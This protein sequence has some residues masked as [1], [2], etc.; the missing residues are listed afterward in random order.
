[1]VSPPFT[2]VF[3]GELLRAEKLT[4]CSARLKPLNHT[5]SLS[6]EETARRNMIQSCR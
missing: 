6:R 5:V 2:V 1:M 4:L 3:A